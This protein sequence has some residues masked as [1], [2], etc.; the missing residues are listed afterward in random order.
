MCPFIQILFTWDLQ[1]L[2]SDFALATD[3]TRL[4]QSQQAVATSICLAGVVSLTNEECK[5]S[6]GRSRT[7]LLLDCQTVCEELLTSTNVLCMKNV[8][9]LKALLIYLVRCDLQEAIQIS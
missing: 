3:L 2:E 8:V 6:L 7:A 5:S 9:S 4:D 1:Q